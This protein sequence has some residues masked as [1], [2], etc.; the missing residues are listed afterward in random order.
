VEFRGNPNFLE[1]KPVTHVG[2]KVGGEIKGRGGCWWF[3]CQGLPK[4]A[5][6]QCHQPAS[7]PAFHLPA[8]APA[9][10]VRAGSRPA[11]GRG[12]RRAQR[13]DAHHRSAYPVGGAPRWWFGRQRA[14][15]PDTRLR[16]QLFSPVDSRR[17]ELGLPR[18]LAF[19]SREALRFPTPLD[20]HP[21][22]RSSFVP[23]S[24]MGSSPSDG[25]G[26]STR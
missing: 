2:V 16:H 21:H 20:G 11:Y 18:A 10:Q 24:L 14:R 1:F 4:A 7:E 25:T 5:H 3:N 12:T 26:I 13:H 17:L 22:S 23:V 15:I 6:W 19:R 8:S 9:I